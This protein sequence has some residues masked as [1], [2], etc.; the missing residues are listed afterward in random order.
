MY[1]ADSVKIPEK[2]PYR[3]TTNS[4]WYVVIRK[5]LI[6]QKSLSNID[7]GIRYQKS[8]TLSYIHALHSAEALKTIQRCICRIITACV[9]Y[10]DVCALLNHRKPYRHYRS[11]PPLANITVSYT[12]LA[13][14]WKPFNTTAPT[15]CYNVIYMPSHSKPFSSTYRRIYDHPH[16]LH[17]HIY[18]FNS[19]P[20]HMLWTTPFHTV[21]RGID[22]LSPT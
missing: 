13:S 6:H 11:R 1:T 14:H 7:T 5:L 9:C 3:N 12:L 18:S 21:Y 20:Q 4:M 8:V 17:Y 22:R 2:Y 16:K 19:V 15:R 10:I